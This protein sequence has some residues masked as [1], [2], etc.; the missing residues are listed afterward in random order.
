LSDTVEVSGQATTVEDS[1]DLFPL[2]AP[3]SFFYA[4]GRMALVAGVQLILQA[5]AGL[6]LL[7]S[8]ICCSVTDAL[9]RS[10]LVFR[11]YPVTRKAE[12]HYEGLIRLIDRHEEQVSSILYVNYFGFPQPIS[13]LL[14][15]C[16]D[17]GIFLI[18]DNAH[19]FL[20]HDAE[21]HFLGSRGDIGIFSF[22]KTVYLPDGGAMVVNNS[23]LSDCCDEVQIQE[24]RKGIQGTY[25]LKRQ[26]LKMIG[27]L[28]IDDKI[29]G[30]IRR[31]EKVL[32]EPSGEAD[33]G[34][35]SVTEYLLEQVRRGPVVSFRR[36]AY[37]EVV[38]ICR[39]EGLKTLFEDLP[40]GVCPY[41]V[42]VV[43]PRGE[44]RDRATRVLRKMGWKVS[45]WPELPGDLEEI[46]DDC[47]SWLSEEV[48]AV[49]LRPAVV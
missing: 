22:P 43:A 38:R 37:R 28:G 42:P 17:R 9:K 40:H 14:R 1:G 23:G 18:E 46:D 10:G 36:S 16:R 6:L 20:S 45:S 24:R 35:S 39:E 25:M 4:T 19:G 13:N 26:V 34:M 8:Y 5:R 21:G 49:F 33:E 15:I 31:R 29:V 47:A 11:Y 32:S 27:A 48:M 30:K 2:N 12:P 44:K 3:C 41:L 7:P